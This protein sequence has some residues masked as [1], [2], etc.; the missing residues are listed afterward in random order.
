MKPQMA[1]F[2]HT[3]VKEAVEESAG[4]FMMRPDVQKRLESILDRFS[5]FRVDFKLAK[6]TFQQALSAF[7]VPGLEALACNALLPPSI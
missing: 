2:D 7:L 3:V 5:V 6:G 4:L 1:K